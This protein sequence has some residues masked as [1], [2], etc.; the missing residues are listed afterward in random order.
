MTSE[1]KE[2]N[3]ITTAAAPPQTNPFKVSSTQSLGILFSAIDGAVGLH[4]W[5]SLESEERR[6]VVW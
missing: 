2:G 6:L 1:S 5:S 3:Q 4:Q